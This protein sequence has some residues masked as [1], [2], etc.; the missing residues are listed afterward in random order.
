MIYY[1]ESLS[2]GTVVDELRSGEPLT[3]KLGMHMVPQGLEETLFEMS[4]DEE[5]HVIVSPEKGFGVYDED[6]VMLYPLFTL[7]NSDKLPIGEMIE[8]TST[9]ATQPAY[10]K[11]LKI[12][13]EVAHIDFNH[14]LAGKELHY[15]VKV[16]DEKPKDGPRV[17]NL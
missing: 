13:N 5:R 6:L 8:I 17:V 3:V 15:W 10:A 11:V 4:L 1:V 9:Q 2:D 12:E 16:V 7:P 14:P